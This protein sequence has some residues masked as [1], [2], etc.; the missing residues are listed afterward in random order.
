MI[1]FTAFM[2]NYTQE[3][4]SEH[5]F[6]NINCQVASFLLKKRLSSKRLDSGCVEQKEA[7]A[8]LFL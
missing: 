1:P 2:A 7:D 3:S 8:L 4:G 6:S 5:I